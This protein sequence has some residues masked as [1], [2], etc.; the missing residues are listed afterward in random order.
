MLTYANNAF[1]I[2]VSNGKR[3][4]VQY[5]RK[6]LG[7][8]ANSKIPEADPRHFDWYRF[9]AGITREQCYA[10][11][12]PVQPVPFQEGQLPPSSAEALDVSGQSFVSTIWGSN[13][14]AFGGEVSVKIACPV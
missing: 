1:M 7:V 10:H 14:L 13:N 4:S 8:L 11:K 6:A 9:V 3:N 2:E 12:L 5:W